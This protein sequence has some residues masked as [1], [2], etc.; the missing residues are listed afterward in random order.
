[1]FSIKSLSSFGFQWHGSSANV[2]QH[3]SLQA[4]SFFVSFYSF[5]QRNKK[6]KELRQRKIHAFWSRKAKE[7]KGESTQDPKGDQPEQVPEQAPEQAPIEHAPTPVPA[8]GLPADEDPT[9]GNQ[10]P[11]DES[12]PNVS[13]DFDDESARCPKNVLSEESKV[14]SVIEPPRKLQRDPEFD[15]EKQPTGLLCGCI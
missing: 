7:A 6:A 14:V 13:T 5:F 2:C 12:T 1:M 10:S 8:E 15:T 4:S 3:L 11:G 9:G